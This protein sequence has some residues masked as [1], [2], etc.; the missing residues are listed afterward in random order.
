MTEKERVIEQL[1]NLDD[2]VSFEEIEKAVYKLNPNPVWKNLKG[3]WFFSL[4]GIFAVISF[5]VLLNGIDLE[6]EKY[7]PLGKIHYLAYC[8]ASL[9]FI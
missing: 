1:K 6:Q 8:T 5:L 9:V 4:A 2:S 3:R 7:K